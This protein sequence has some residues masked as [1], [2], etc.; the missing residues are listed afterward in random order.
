M[1][2]NQSHFHYGPVL[3]FQDNLFPDPINPEG[4]LISD[5]KEINIEPITDNVTIKTN[6]LVYTNINMTDK[7]EYSA[8]AVAKTSDLRIEVTVVV[9]YVGEGERPIINLTETTRVRALAPEKVAAGN[10]VLADIQTTEGSKRAE[11]RYLYDDT[12]LSQDDEKALALYRSDPEKGWVVEEY[13]GVDTVNNI[14]WARTSTPDGKFEVKDSRNYDSDGDGLSDYEERNIYRDV[15]SDDVE[16]GNIGWTTGYTAHWQISSGAAQSGTHYWYI[17][18]DIAWMRG[19]SLQSEDFSLPDSQRASLSFYYKTSGAGSTEASLEVDNF[20]PEIIYLEPSTTWKEVTMDVDLFSRFERNYW[21]GGGGNVRSASHTSTTQTSGTGQSVSGG[22]EGGKLSVKFH[23]FSVDTASI[24]IDDITLKATTSPRNYDTDG[25]GLTDGEEVLQYGTSPVLQDTDGD[26][27]NDGDE[28]NKYKTD[29]TL[30]DT[31]NDGVMDSMD[32]DPL[33]DL[34]ITVKIRDIHALDNTDSP[35]SDPDMF[36]K[37]TIN[38]VT[39]ESPTYENLMHYGIDFYHSSILDFTQDVPD[40]FKEVPIVLE[41]WDDDTNDWFDWTSDDFDISHGPHH[42]LMLN[43]NLTTGLWGGDDNP[44]DADGYGHSRGDNDGDTEDRDGEIRFSI[45][46]SD[47]D[48]DGLT[49]QEELHTYH[50]NP[51][52]FTN[53]DVDGDGLDGHGEVQEWTKPNLPDTD[54]DGLWDGLE[55]KLTNPDRQLPYSPINEPDGKKFI[56]AMYSALSPM[57]KVLENYSNLLNYQLLSN[58]AGSG[59]IGLDNLTDID[60]YTRSEEVDNLLLIAKALGELAGEEGGLVVDISELIVA[61]LEET[62]RFANTIYIYWGDYDVKQYCEYGGVVYQIGYGLD[63]KE[64]LYR[65]LKGLSQAYSENMPFINEGFHW[66][67][68]NHLPKIIESF[69][70]VSEIDTPYVLQIKHPDGTIENKTVL[71]PNNSTMDTASDI[72]QEIL[73]FAHNI[74]IFLHISNKPENIP[75]VT[76]TVGEIAQNLVNMAYHLFMLLRS[77]R[78]LLTGLM[79]ANGGV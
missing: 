1:E 21:G 55:V 34:N 63:W 51:A 54:G 4:E 33:V 12:G 43:Y 3:P 9:D 17:S 78:I 42:S 28:V 6:P 10:E 2:T 71:D 41:L 23:F 73:K 31:D 13:S 72:E 5:G 66:F 68:E 35:W 59:D 39:Q 52:Y 61:F 14:V 57:P 64:N 70:E 60:I 15:F 65:N 76:V 16:N 49:Y 24:F 77:Q 20:K 36:V 32:T 45:V 58:K 38:G 30:A 27:W 53:D 48:A 56:E 47:Y 67:C 19:I 46:Q 29:P 18:T 7:K 8:V 40:S 22:Q 79:N 44:Y 50:T 75:H 69:G 26:N 62:Y 37:I 25:D 11:I 74:S